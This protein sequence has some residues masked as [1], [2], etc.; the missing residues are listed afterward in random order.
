MAD[1]GLDVSITR[2][3]GA[4]VACLCGEVD[5]T[6]APA[7][8]TAITEAM[9]S[10]PDLLVI[11]LLAV[12]FLASAGLHVLFEAAAAGRPEVRV[13]AVRR[14]CVRPIRLTGLDTVVSV[15]TTVTDALGEGCH[16]VR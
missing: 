15:H 1:T 9:R 16:R 4:S 5:V 8:R 12:T 7:L 10:E 11:D 2:L 14:E 13:V 6:T 3:T